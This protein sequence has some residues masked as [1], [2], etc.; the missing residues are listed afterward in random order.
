M[1]ADVGVVRLAFCGGRSES[2]LQLQ[3][4]EFYYFGRNG[5][6]KCRVAIKMS[7]FSYYEPFFCNK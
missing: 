1:N 2:A 5:V 4:E 7:F 3:E 6:E